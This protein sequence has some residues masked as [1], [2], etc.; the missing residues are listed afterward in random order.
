MHLSTISRSRSSMLKKVNFAGISRWSALVATRQSNCQIDKVS[1]YIIQELGLITYIIFI[2]C[3]VKLHLS[4]QSIPEA[5][6]RNVSARNLNE[7]VVYNIQ[8]ISYNL[9]TRAYY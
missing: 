4:S 9:C 6:F 2:H 7:H 8:A 3:T 5:R 1:F